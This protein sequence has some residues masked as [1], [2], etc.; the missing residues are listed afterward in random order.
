MENRT[1]DIN[2]LVPNLSKIARTLAYSSIYL[3]VAGGAMVFLSCSLQNIAFSPAA[4]LIMILV[5]YAVY[6]LNR[7]TDE[8]EDSVNHLERYSFTKRYGGFLFRTA[9]LAY[10][11]AA[12][13]GLFFGIEAFLVTM[14]PLFSGILYSIPLLPGRSRYSRI[15]EVPVLKSATVA[16]AWAIP[17]ALLPAC[18][19]ATGVTLQTWLTALF[20]FSLVFVN[21]VMFDIRDIKGDRASGVETIPVILGTE[22]TILFLSALNLGAGVI[23]ITLG[24]ALFSLRQTAFLCFAV[25]YAQAYIL[26]FKEKTAD[27]IT[28][29]IFMDGQF[30]ILAGVYFLFLTI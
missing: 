24:Q 20:F 2:R 3:S 5:T 17:P 14:I 1:S 27:K 22:K 8:A 18:L 11:G 4:A 15:K 23:I 7:K 6:N 9:A 19:L 10:I 13:F 21:T 25:I 26:L 29:E 30:I 12:A 16:L 28:S